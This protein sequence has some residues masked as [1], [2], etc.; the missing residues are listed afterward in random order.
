M[1]LSKKNFQDA[2][3]IAMMA[4]TQDSTVYARLFVV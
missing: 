4:T 3:K 1:K 2:V